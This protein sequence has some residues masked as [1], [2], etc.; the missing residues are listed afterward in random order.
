[1][2][3]KVQN[4]TN[5]YTSQ[6][7]KANDGYTTIGCYTSKNYKNYSSGDRCLEEY[8]VLSFHFM[9]FYKGFRDEI[10]N[11]KGVMLKVVG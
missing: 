9:S 3:E 10:Q 2:D 1:V 11:T 7:C 6:N 5:K 8:E 4:C